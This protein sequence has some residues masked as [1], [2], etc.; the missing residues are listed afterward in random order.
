LIGRAVNANQTPSDE[1]AAVSALSTA[2]PEAIAMSVAADGGGVTL[3][4]MVE[5]GLGVGLAGAVLDAVGVGVAD[6]G[7]LLVT[8]TLGDGDGPPGLA[9]GLVPPDGDGVARVGEAVGGAVGPTLG[10]EVSGLAVGPVIPTLTTYIERPACPDPC[11]M[12]INCPEVGDTWTLLGFTDSVTTF[13]APVSMGAQP[14]G[15]LVGQTVL[16]GAWW[17]TI[18][19]FWSALTH[20]TSFCVP[21][22]GVGRRPGDVACDVPMATC[23]GATGPVMSALPS[24]N[25]T[26]MT[27]AIALTAPSGVQIPRCCRLPVERHVPVGV[28]VR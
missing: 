12:T 8:A 9:D 25:P 1:Y 16:T 5:V 18:R 20:A 15:S 14:A 2:I 13:W 19:P 6:E 26:S 17:T 23:D 24:R 7:G 22:V 21:R 4:M 3:G 11:P 27:A 28:A 10:D